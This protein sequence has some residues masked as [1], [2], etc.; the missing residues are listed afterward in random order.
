MK[1]TNILLWGALVVTSVFMSSYRS[2]AA[3]NGWDCTGAESGLGNPTGCS[4]SGCHGTTATTGITVALELDSAGTL[5]VMKYKPDSTYTFK[6]TGTNTTASSLPKFGFQVACILGSAAQATP[7]NAGTFQ[8]TGLPSGVHFSAPQSGNFVT[9]IVEHSLALSPASGTGGNGTVYQESF[10]WTAPAAGTGTVSFW[11]V[12]NAVNGDGNASS[13]DKWN[14]QH[15]IIEEDTSK[16]VVNGIAEVSSK[17]A[18]NLYP[19]PASD[20][21]YL[22]IKTQAT[23]IY[24]LNVFSADGRTVLRQAA[25]ITGDETNI[26]IDISKLEAGIYFINLFKGHENTVVRLV[27]K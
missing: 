3:S 25:E 15:L 21:V 24:N 8:Q 20:F 14:T 17:P 13:A 6:I 12:V 10:K 18:L 1:K 7:T 27:K 4:H 23:G 2:G 16:P 19:N 5:P 22:E 11:G 26:A 9:N